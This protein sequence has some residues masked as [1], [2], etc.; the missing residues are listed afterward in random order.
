ML[1]FLYHSRCLIW[2][3]M[4]CAAASSFLLCLLRLWSWG[5]DTLSSQAVAVMAFPGQILKSCWA[6][7]RPGFAVEVHWW[8]FTAAL[9]LHV[10]WLF[11]VFGNEVWLLNAQRGSKGQRAGTHCPLTARISEILC[12]SAWSLSELKFCSGKGIGKTGV[13]L[14]IGEDDLSFLLDPSGANGPTAPCFCNYWA[15]PTGHRKRLVER[16]WVKGVRQRWREGECQEQCL[17]FSGQRCLLSAPVSPAFKETSKHKP[18]NCTF[19][20]P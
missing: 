12:T 17:L 20:I 10:C 19:I 11:Q 7:W 4:G 15:W 14:C 8:N 1:V 13:G 9:V 6:I 2:G 3:I 5:Y 16:F 18:E